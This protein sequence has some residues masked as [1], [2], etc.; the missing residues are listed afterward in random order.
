MSASTMA[1]APQSVEPLTEPGRRSLALRPGA[2]LTW[3]VLVFFLLNLA[4]VITTVLLDSFS[5][6]WF[7]TWMP[8]GSSFIKA[9]G[10]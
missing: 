2:W 3:G 7:D 4:G 9:R 8:G 6:K 1:P 5:T 10:V